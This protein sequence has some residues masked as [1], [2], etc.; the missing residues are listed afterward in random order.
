MR[1]EKDE[2][3]NLCVELHNMARWDEP[4]AS[5]NRLNAL[6]FRR[7]HDR[8]NGKKEI[9]DPELTFQ[10]NC[11]ASMRTRPKPKQKRKF[12]SLLSNTGHNL[13]K[14]EPTTS[15]DNADEGSESEQ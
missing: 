2:D 11:I 7:L 15:K 1:R 10:P 8:K 12:R 9:H 3:K 13:M 4:S 6:V 5:E 14:T